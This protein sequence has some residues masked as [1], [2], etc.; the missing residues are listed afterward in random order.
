MSRMS[1]VLMYLTTVLSSICVWGDEEGNERQAIDPCS[2]EA[3]SLTGK[4]QFHVQYKAT[5][6][7]LSTNKH[8]KSSEK[9]IN[10]LSENEISLKPLSS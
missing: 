1:P 2:P 9:D 4:H 7:K 8:C 5:R 6:D 10:K 3:D